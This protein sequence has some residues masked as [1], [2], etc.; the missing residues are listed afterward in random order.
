MKT[1][2]LK[3]FHSTPLAGHVSINK[4]YIRLSANFFWV[5]M[6]RDV[7]KFVTECLLCQQT[8]YS[9]KA[10]AGLLQRLPIPSLIW[11]EITM[12]FICN[13]FL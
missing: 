4:T 5:H 12:D 9:T 11:D 10:P 8:K 6:R 1:T 3:E 13:H 7:E 2:L